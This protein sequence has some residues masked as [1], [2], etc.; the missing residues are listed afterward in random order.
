[1]NVLRI[2]RS[3]Q[4]SRHA[5]M[6]ASV[7][8]TWPG[9]LHALEHGGAAVLERDV[10]VGQHLAL[11]HQRDHVIDVRIR[12]HVVHAHPDA[13]L[14]QAAREIEEA[15]FVFLPAPLAFA[16]TDVDAIGRGVLRDHQQLLHAGARQLLAFAQHF[17]DGPAG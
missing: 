2:V 11:G 5:L 1:M 15:R 3:G 13:E 16:V 9:P 7:F 14:A 12:I 17:V 6:R 10:E 8:S 4:T